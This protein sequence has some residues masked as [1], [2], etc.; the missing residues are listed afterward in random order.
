MEIGVI[1]SWKDLELARRAESAG[2][3]L[4]G[5]GDSHLLFREL[6]SSLGAM[7]HLT[8]SIEIGPT[9][10]NP[11]TRHPTVTAGGVCTIDDMSD[12]RAFLGLA[13]GETAVT[14]IGARPA[15]LRDLEETITLTQDLCAGTSVEYEGNTLRIEWLQR[16]DHEGDSRDVPV[17]LAADG[18]KTK[19]LAGAVADG[20]FMNGVES[21]GIEASIE[22]VEEGAREAG[23]DPSSIRKWTVAR[24]NVG[25]DRDAA[26]DEIRSALAGTGKYALQTALDER[27]VPP[28][29][30][31]SLAT[32]R[33]EYNPQKHVKPGGGPNAELIDRLG[34]TDFLADR[35]A[36]AGTP[37]DCLEKLQEIDSVGGV[38]GVLLIA[39]G[40]NKRAFIDRMGDS[41]IPQL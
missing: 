13:S 17:F 38:D 37:D 3:D 14:T 30:Q 41:V 40:G 1:A 24:S 39:N 32:L 31:E 7:A 6:Y 22:T 33:E 20:V 2:F 34:L 25:E 27:N 18:P 28:K 10:T 21:D 16:S 5:V 36:V 4:F 35:F 12:G 15:R 8:E 29:H 23:R 9:M 19:R 26:I 11:I